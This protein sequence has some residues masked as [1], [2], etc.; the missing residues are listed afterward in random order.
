MT[1]EGVLAQLSDVDA[2]AC[3]LMGEAAGDGKDGSSVE[4]RI[5]VGCVVRN[6]AA[7]PGYGGPT[8][9]G[10]CLRKLQF[11]C[12]NEND[13]N[14][15]RMLAMARVLLAQRDGTA[16]GGMLDP[17]LRESLY[18]AHGLAVGILQD[19]TKGANHYLTAAL[20]AQSPPGWANP[21]KIVA[22]IG[23]HVFFKL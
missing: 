20:L 9:K 4:E 7:A 23:S 8:L 5:A 6:R 14:R 15:P 17:F 13:P 3:T 12:W 10:V 11:S 21:A 19:R 2:L 18:L 22:R 16:L 1:D